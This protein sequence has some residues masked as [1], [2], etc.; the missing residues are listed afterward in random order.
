MDE[1]GLISF[2]MP[3]VVCMTKY[4]S[5]S[6]SG[7]F[8]EDNPLSTRNKPHF[9][10]VIDKIITNNLVGKTVSLL[11]RKSKPALEALLRLQVVKYIVSGFFKGCTDVLVNLLKAC[12]SLGEPPAV[13]ST[14]IADPS[15]FYRDHYIVPISY[16]SK[17][18]LDLDI[19]YFADLREK[20]HDTEKTLD[21]KQLSPNDVGIFIF[22]FAPLLASAPESSPDSRRNRVPAAPSPASPSKCARGAMNI[23]EV[24]SD[25]DQNNDD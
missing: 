25:S 19:L 11:L 20:V 9:A 8:A 15:A 16:S 4:R 24:N 5:R 17:L 2:F 18:S 23:F 6:Q 10:K 7:A 3:I 13:P 22:A 21:R 14:C 12:P 1:G